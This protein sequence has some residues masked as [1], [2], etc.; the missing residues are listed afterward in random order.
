M[1][2]YFIGL[3]S[4]L[5]FGISIGTPLAIELIYR[6]QQL[7]KGETNGEAKMFNKRL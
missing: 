4:G 5:F 3:V 7:I 6:R 2:D 1:F